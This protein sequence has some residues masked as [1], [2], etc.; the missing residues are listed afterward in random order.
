MSDAFFVILSLT[1]GYVVGRAHQ[2][3][4]QVQVN[5]NLAGLMESIAAHGNVTYM[6]EK[7][8]RFVKIL[9]GQEP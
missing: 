2:K 8:A 4:I 5:E 7:T 1:I 3:V 9:R 6:R